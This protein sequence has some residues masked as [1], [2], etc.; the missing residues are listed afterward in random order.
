M[1][2]IRPITGLIALVT[3]GTLAL[4]GCSG[5]GSTGGTS[6][7]S[8]V[9][10]VMANSVPSYQKNFNP[11]SSSVNL[12]TKG[13]IYE[14][15]ILNSP[16][17]TDGIPW[18]ATK[19]SWANGGKTAKFTIRDG[20]N[21]SDGKPFTAKDVAFSFNLLH[22]FP[23]TNTA[24]L[25]VASASASGNTVTVK[26][27]AVAYSYQQALGNFTPVPEHLWADQDASKW[28]N[29]Q[30]VGTGPFTLGKYSAQLLS[31]SKNPKYWQADKIK[32]DKIDYPAATPQTFVSNLG[33][34]KYD[35]SGG[36]V[37]NIDKVY[38]SKDKEHNKYW[39]P[40]DGLVNLV[41]DLQKK[42]FDDVQLRKAISLGLNRQELSQTAEQGYEPVANPTGLV[43]PALQS[44]LDPKYKDA[45]FTQ[46]VAKANAILDKAGYKKGADGVRVGPDGKKLSF[47]LSV[48]SGYTDWVTMTK[49]IQQQLKQIGIQVKP[50]GVSSQSWSAALHSG[51]FDMTIAGA[52]MGTGAYSLYRSFMSKD[53]SAPKGKNATQNYARWEDP[54]TE[55]YLSQ[56]ESTND[57]QKQLKAIQGLEGIVVDK[58]PVIPMLDSANWFEYRTARFTGWPTEDNPYAMPAPYSFPDSMLVIQHLRPVGK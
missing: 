46:D 43:L 52:S 37:A 9:L 7:A 50:Q 53:L 26:L 2:K 51:S 14:P 31:F 19:M 27:N 29:P 34:G 11:F 56:Y 8:N 1:R 3:A 47:D 57:K 25:P 45:K 21:W 33:A 17:K 6:G 54:T 39:F 12:G 41:M 55:K 42:P 4:A 48:P 20:V 22:K 5:G 32:V 36:F 58:L 40:G 49:L 15:L 18:L 30:P 13:L 38:V 44:Y 23:A 16:V 24:A 10:T 35:W 28:T